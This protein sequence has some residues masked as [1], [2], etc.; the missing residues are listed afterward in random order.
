MYLTK[1]VY[2]MIHWNLKTNG[3][4]RKTGNLTERHEPKVE[5][6]FGMTAIDREHPRR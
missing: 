4:Y 6:H 1:L 3:E 2:V 5:Q